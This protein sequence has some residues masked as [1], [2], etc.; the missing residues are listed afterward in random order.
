MRRE[1]QT[2]LGGREEVEVL[3]KIFCHL[4]RCIVI[5]GDILVSPDA[6]QRPGAMAL[7]ILQRDIRVKGE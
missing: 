6:F 3:L 5:K 1:P 7:D 4:I 2:Q